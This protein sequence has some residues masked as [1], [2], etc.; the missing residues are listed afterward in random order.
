MSAKIH[1]AAA[2]AGVGIFLTG[3]FLAYGWPALL[4]LGGVAI[5]GTALVTQ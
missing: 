4:M 2:I 1:S 5:V 3:L